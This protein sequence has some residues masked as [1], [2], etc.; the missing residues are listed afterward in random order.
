MTASVAS[1]ISADGARN[2]FRR[3][4]STTAGYRR[5]RWTGDFNPAYAGRVAVLIYV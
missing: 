1:L 3:G 4:S 2:Q 5:D